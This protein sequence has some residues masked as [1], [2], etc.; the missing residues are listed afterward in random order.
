M[1]DQPQPFRFRQILRLPGIELIVD[2]R[3]QM[4]LRRIPGLRQVVIEVRLVDR[5][6]AAS[7]S[8]YAVSRTRRAIG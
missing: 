1:S 6:D 7:M 4:F 2:H 5:L 8:E 3:V